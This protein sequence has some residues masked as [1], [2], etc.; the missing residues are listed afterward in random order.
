[1]LLRGGWRDGSAVKSTDGSSE[2]PE[3]NSHQ[4]HGGCS[5]NLKTATV[6][7]HII[8]NKSLKRKKKIQ[9]RV[10]DKQKH[11]SW[12]KYLSKNVGSVRAVVSGLHGEG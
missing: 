12:G 11:L 8:I 10:R 2:G 7:L 3:F 1:M 9:W 4:P 6:Y 5:G